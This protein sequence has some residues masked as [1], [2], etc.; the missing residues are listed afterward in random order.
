MR[1]KEL[2]SKLKA[3][4]KERDVQ[5]EL[6]EKERSELALNVNDLTGAKSDLEAKLEKRQEVILELQGQL[7]TLQCELD[8]LRAEYDKL[9]DDSIKQTG[10]LVKSHNEERET[11]KDTFAKE[12]EALESQCDQTKMTAIVLQANLE[13]MAE[14]NSFLQQELKDVQRLYRDVSFVS[15]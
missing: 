4:I 14:T 13:D 2:S 3:L 5:I 12:K 10:D 15:R 1:D 8:E 9:L 11:L 7:S 6:L